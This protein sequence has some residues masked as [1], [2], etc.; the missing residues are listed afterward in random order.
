MI[1]IQVLES[2]FRLFILSALITGFCVSLYVSYKV[3]TK[4]CKIKDILKH[5]INEKQIDSIM[6]LFGKPN[7]KVIQEY[8]QTINS[9]NITI[10]EL[11]KK[12]DKMQKDSNKKEVFEEKK[13]EIYDTEN[14]KEDLEKQEIKKYDEM[15]NNEDK[16]EETKQKKY[17]IENKEIIYISDIDEYFWDAGKFIVK[18]NKGSIGMIQK[19]FKIGFNRAARIM[20]EL[21]E[22]GIVGVEMG[23]VPRKVLMSSDEFDELWIDNRI[24]VRESNV[25]NIQNNNQLWFSSALNRIDM[26]NNKYDYMTGEDF[27]I[28]VAQIL[29]NIGFINVRTTKGSGDQGVDIL[30]EKDNIKYAIQCKRYSE[31]VGNKAVQ[32]VFA[33]KSFYHC[34]IGIVVT[35]NYFSKS[36]KELALETGVVLWDKDILD[37][38]IISEN[39]SEIKTQEIEENKVN[40]DELRNTCM[41]IHSI[42]LETYK[43]FGIYV[44]YADFTFED[45][46]AIFGISPES[47]I[48]VKEIMNLEK[49]LSLSLNTDIK[50]KML[51]ERGY[52][53]IFMPILQ[54]KKRMEEMLKDDRFSEYYKMCSEEKTDG[55]IKGQNMSD[56]IIEKY[57]YIN[58][59]FTTFSL[60]KENKI[61]ILGIC[62]TRISAAN[63][64]CSFCIKLKEEYLG[65]FDFSVAINLNEAIAIYTN[66]NEIEF[67]GGKEPNGEV[68]IGIPNWMDKAR[69]ELLNGNKDEFLRMAEEANGYLD[70]FMSEVK[71]IY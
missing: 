34:D 36:A 69:D 39:V 15:K 44:K 17:T 10:E 7:N 62:N 60:K 30:A 32:E 45:G 52:I 58:G 55:I 35:N 33:G 40:E 9:Q 43:S 70:E 41:I 14:K 63:L 49:E 1:I 28:F 12:V 54:F 13:Q 29:V 21:C 31:T 61:E 59:D 67:F 68:A 53:G 57:Y 22:A 27:E 37:K 46:N 18:Q 71:K 5:F 66:E 23:T 24:K 11:T 2:F 64:Y 4:N 48:R 51:S 19:K 16:F 65:K 6:S 50:I 38:Y 56:S 25:P 26:Y 8:E 42:I 20:D 47:G 3:V